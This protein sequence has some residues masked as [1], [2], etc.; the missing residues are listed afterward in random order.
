MFLA[1]EA[2]KICSRPCAFAIQRLLAHLPNGAR[3]DFGEKRRI[4]GSIYVHAYSFIHGTYRT[5]RSIPA[6]STSNRWSANERVQRSWRRS[7]EQHHE[8]SGRHWD[9]VSIGCCDAEKVPA[10]L[11]KPI[12]TV[13]HRPWLLVDE[14]AAADRLGKQTTHLLADLGEIKFDELTPA[15]LRAILKTKQSRHDPAGLKPCPRIPDRHL[16]LRS[17]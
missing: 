17:R 13:D 4:F 16:P 15:L 5:S 3:P 8:S 1:R 7:E 11:R 6:F 10:L 2:S 9:C 12:P 14:I